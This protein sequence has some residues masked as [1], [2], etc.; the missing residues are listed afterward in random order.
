M[1]TIEKSIEV[2]VPVR[3][4]YDQWTQFEEFPKF[5]EGVQEVRQL[6]NTHLYWRA[7]IAGKTPIGMRSSQNSDQTS[8]SHGR[9]QREQRMRE[10]SHST[11]CQSKSLRSCCNWIMSL[12]VP[13]KMLAMRSEL[14]Q[15][16]L[17]AI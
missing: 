14:C 6:D 12:K 16:A 13:W 2:N 3:T 7:Q 9:A 11:V 5:M 10:W 15:F 17:Q 8:V 1:S 4:A